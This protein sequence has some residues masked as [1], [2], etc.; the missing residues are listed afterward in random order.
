METMNNEQARER[1]TIAALWI[2]CGLLIAALAL[3]VNILWQWKY[4]GTPL[5]R[6]A[7]VQVIPCARVVDI[8]AE[9]DDLKNRAENKPSMKD[10]Q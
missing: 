9:W 6:C 8:E 1:A 10:C 3:A 2:V 7:P 5:A 4:C